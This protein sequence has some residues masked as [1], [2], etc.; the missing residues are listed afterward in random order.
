MADTPKWEDTAPVP[1]AATE[2]E[3]P[4]FEDTV[5]VFEETTPVDGE[6]DT[7]YGKA[8]G[9]GIRE[10]IAPTTVSP[11]EVMAAEG[12]TTGEKAA[13]IGSGVLADIGATIAV[14]AGA[15]AAAGSVVPGAGT[16]AGAVA[17]GLFALYKVYGQ[18]KLHTE[19]TGEQKSAPRMLVSLAA[20][21][22][23]LLKYGGGA[24]SKVVKGVTQAGLEA[25]RAKAYGADDTM[26]AV[27]AGV[28]GV[29]AGAFHSRAERQGLMGLIG[30]P[31]VKPDVP[32]GR[33]KITKSLL[34]DSMA[35]VE[36]QL[37]EEAGE[38][39][40]G[41]RVTQRM[42]E[43]EPEEKAMKTI[44]K[45]S[46]EQ[47]E[48]PEAV[49]QALGSDQLD[50]L[51]NSMRSSRMQ[52]QLKLA[53]ETAEVQGPTSELGRR[54][55]AAAELVA[56]DYQQFAAFVVDPAL[57]RAKRMSREELMAEFTQVKSRIMQDANGEQILDNTYQMYRTQ[58]YAFEVLSESESSY[59]KEFNLDPLNSAP[60]R[61]MLDQLYALRAI[62]RASGLN[63]SVMGNQLSN[64]QYAHTTMMSG[65]QQM[66][67]KLN[68]MTR[69]SKL[70]PG[71][72]Y[73]LLTNKEERV[74]MW[75]KLGPEKQAAVV[76]WRDAWNK[77]RDVGRENGINIGFLED[78]AP[79]ATKTVPDMVTGIRHEWEK[80]LKKYGAA[81]A[82]KPAPEVLKAMLANRE[83]SLSTK[84]F[85]RVLEHYLQEPIENSV[86]L[87]KAVSKVQDLEV[88]KKNFGYEARAAFARKGP[89]PKFIQETD[90]NR[91]FLGASE[92][93]SKTINM[94]PAISEM[95]S[96]IPI[97]HAMG[98]T[99]SAN[100]VSRMLSSVS[101]GSD[102]S[103]AA[104]MDAA[105]NKWKI[106][107]I[108]LAEDIPNVPGLR[109][110]VKTARDLP[111]IM[112]MLMSQ[113]YPNYLG[114]T[115]RG[116]F[117]NLWQPIFMT[118]PEIGG[119]YGQK[120]VL[121]S[122]MEALKDRGSGISWTKTMQDNNWMPAQ[123][124][125]EAFRVVRQ[126]FVDNP[127]LAKTA[128]ALDKWSE[129]AMLLYAKSDAMNRYVTYKVAKNWVQDIVAG[130]PEAM[131]ALSSIGE[132][133]K[134]AVDRAIK[135]GANAD[136]VTKLLA[137]HLIAKTQFNYGK[138]A[139][140]EYARQLGPMF[141]MFS[142][143]PLSIGSMAYEAKKTGT[144]TKFLAKIMAPFAAL[145]L[146]DA[147]VVD[148]KN[149][150]RM[151][152]LLG[153]GGLKDLAPGA[154]LTGVTALSNPPALETLDS[155]KEAGIAAIRRDT[156][157]AK[158]HAKKAITPFLPIYTGV[159][160]AGEQLET[161]YTGKEPR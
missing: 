18:E 80:L 56:Q 157:K 121:K 47:A 27:A 40:L 68:A 102:G 85:L 62:D 60:V 17:G 86:Q 21:F 33:P 3:I 30:A 144:G 50:D 58:K 54:R 139:L 12:Q 43:A 71:E 84:N 120:L 123:F 22:N 74:L 131:K 36:S 26:T 89:I 130:K 44:I 73:H 132:G 153:H 59:L 7:D 105:A 19:L 72:V 114:L 127:A 37:A 122:T 66:H 87:R 64:S 149:N 92:N 13:R 107:M 41:R 158:Q 138:H 129:W 38:M 159:K 49:R 115:I 15:G 128:G 57:A 35:H 117:R 11:E 119:K 124:S 77:L 101:G 24:A 70:T 65:F 25:S 69:K 147:W 2:S 32:G 28:G 78:Y 126:A 8:I 42:V 137:D 98:L 155:L 79:Q 46:P 16:L 51:A 20:E 152:A 31:A 133:Y 112:G 154:A 156:A 14:S 5:P 53:Q 136:E 95:A 140:G 55:Q 52:E 45:L 116:P 99:E 143:W 160:R 63:M 94:S 142:K 109:W 134:V 83:E 146:L 161:I 150:P 106:S 151:Q 135:R 110:G 29:A 4:R 148:S 108:K 103:L 75:D 9:L 6:S 93:L 141:S 125:G 76:A 91:L 10:A 104:F 1:P 97:L 67:K 88:L 61:G 48:S 111:E 82:K 96:N 118:G 145:A 100:Y 113:I 81:D 34:D 39:D 23:P 90:I